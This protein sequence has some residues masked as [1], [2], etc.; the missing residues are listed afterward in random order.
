[1]TVD[2]EGQ[3]ICIEYNIRSPGTIVY[4]MADGPFAGEHTRELLQF[5]TQP[6]NRKKYLI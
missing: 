3:I 6:Q 4:Q 1:M 5:L 2:E